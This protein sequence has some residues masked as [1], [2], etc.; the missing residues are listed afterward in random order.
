[1]LE[2]T[3]L[4]SGS[5]GN[6]SV[7]CAGA[8]MIL[9]DAGLSPKATRERMYT[10]LRRKP[11]EATDLL[12]THLDADHWR[13]NWRKP[14]ERSSIRV[15][16]HQEH[17]REAVRCGVPAARIVPFDDWCDMGDG[18]R[19]FACRTPHDDRGT[20]A[21]LIER[22]CG[23]GVTRLGFATDL[24]RVAPALIEHFRDI[25][26]LALESNYD[27]ELERISER[28]W[29]LKERIMGG[30]GHLSNEESV[31]A[32][33][34]IAATGVPQAIVLL[35]LSQQCNRP[36]IVERTW[37]ERAAHLLD[38]VVISDQFRPAPTVTARPTQRPARIAGVPASLF[39]EVGEAVEPKCLPFVETSEAGP[40]TAWRG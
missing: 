30:K 37:R 9:I 18:L 7:V 26:L 34:R 6:A 16:V 36:D 13:E 4:A 11:E 12:L 38:R 2:L 5:Q 20:T 14:I 19:L 10:A 32:A 25:D 33:L 29:F 24:G 31:E 39:A 15:R 22:Q 21:Y 3:V 28:P 17:L 27:E 1:V 40:S 23:Q 35:H 8:R